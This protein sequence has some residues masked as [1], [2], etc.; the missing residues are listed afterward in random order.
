MLLGSMRGGRCLP[1]V[2]LALFLSNSLRAALI[3]YDGAGYAPT[4]SISGLNG[5]VGWG[6]GWT[7][8]NSVVAGSLLINGVAT[9]GNRFVTDGNNDGSSRVIGTNGFG[10]LLQN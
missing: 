1:I 9:N 8:N 2:L 5:G 10:A 4:N 3:A 6:G 7:G